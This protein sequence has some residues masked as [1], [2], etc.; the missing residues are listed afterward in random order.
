MSGGTAPESGATA[1][2]LGGRQGASATSDNVEGDPLAA[3]IWVKSAVH[4]GGLVGGIGLKAVDVALLQSALVE[5]D[6]RGKLLK[7][8]ISR[9]HAELETAGIVHGLEEDG[10]AAA[11]QSLVEAV[12][13]GSP[14]AFARKVA[15]GEAPEPGQGGYI[16]YLQ[17]YRGVPFSELSELSPNSTEK[18]RTVVHANDVLAIEHPPTQPKD[19]TSVSG[20]RLPA[21]ASSSSRSASEVAGPHTITDKDRVLA[22]CD[23]LCEEDVQGWLR[24]VPEI[25]LAQVDQTT[26]RVPGAGISEANIAVIGSVSGGPGVATTEAV[27]VGA[28]EEEGAVEGSASIRAKHL[29]VH[30]AIVG[31]SEGEGAGIEV[32][33]YCA[34]REVRNRSIEAAHVLIAEDSHFAKLDAEQDIRVDG[35]P[36]APWGGQGIWDR[37]E[38][39]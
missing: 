6:G 4:A 26:G 25:V 3:A 13:A 22:E 32:D 17:N 12:E 27:F 29:I 5:P 21:P 18:K 7:L 16:E 28:G 37:W 14:D 19:G 36:D 15:K 39:R 20:D 1:D 38:E 11:A 34:A 2:G 31:D 33:E 9:V 23:G 35:T 24:V 8:V 10:I 30:G